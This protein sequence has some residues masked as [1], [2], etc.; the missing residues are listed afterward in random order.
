MLFQNLRVLNHNHSLL[1]SCINFQIFNMNSL[2]NHVHSNSPYSSQNPNSTYCYLTN[3]NNPNPRFRIILLNMASK[4]IS[5]EYQGLRFTL[6]LFMTRHEFPL[7]LI[8]FHIDFFKTYFGSIQ[9]FCS[10]ES[11]IWHKEH[12]ILENIFLTYSFG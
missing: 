3:N 1:Y 8:M 5:D 7:F 4:F 6:S 12:T 11:K 2:L 10:Y 9:Y